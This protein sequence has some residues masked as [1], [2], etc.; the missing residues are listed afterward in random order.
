MERLLQLWRRLRGRGSASRRIEREIDEEL[1]FHLEMRTRE[2]IAAGMAPEEAEHR[3]RERLGELDRVRD[4]G[5]SIRARR[6]GAPLFLRLAG[7]VAQDVRFGLRSMLRTPGFT[8]V[9]VLTLTLGIG[10]TTVIF[11]VADGVLLQP[12]PYREP[13]RLVQFRSPS[14]S[15][16]TLATWADGLSTLDGISLFTIGS[17]EVVGPDGARSVSSLPVDG[18]FF[19]V[20][21]A[22]AAHGRTLGPEDQGADAPLAAVITD[23]LW[24][25][26][27]GAD[28]AALGNTLSFDGRS[29]TIVG[30]MPPG[31]SFLLYPRHDLF[32]PVSV[33][34]RAP[35][36]ALG[37]LADG[38]TPAQSREQA[39]ALAR[40]IDPIAGAELS[41]FS[42]LTLYERVVSADRDGILLLSGAVCFVLLIAC[43]NVANL[44]MARSLARAGEIAVRAA[45]GAGQGRLARQM[46]TESALL[47]LLGGGLG[48]LLAATS[49]PILLRM[50]PRYFARAENIHVDLR[51]ALFAAAVSVSTGLLFGMAPV[52]FAR[53]ADL[54]RTMGAD[55]LRSGSSRLRQRLLQGL[56][57]LEV[58][59]SLVLLIGTGMMLHAFF[60]LLPTDP[61]FDARGK[62]AF[63]VRLPDRR[64]PDDRAKVAFHARALRELRALPGVT[65][66]TTISSAPMVGMVWVIEAVPEGMDPASEDLPNVWL[67]RIAPDYHDVLAIPIVR[68]RP[69][70]DRPPDG[71]PEMVIS[72]EAARRMWP[73]GDALGKTLSVRAPEATFLVVGVAAD[74]RRLGLDLRARPIVWARYRDVPEDRVT[75][76]AS[77]AGPPGA[78]A[79]EVGALVR[80]LDPE[81]P[82]FDLQTMDDLLSESVSLPRLY[83][84]V[85]GA[86]GGVAILLAAFG[87]YGVMSYVVGQRARELG[88]RLALGAT[89]A[90]MLRLVMT[91][92]LVITLVG[93]ALGIAGALALTR[94]L[95]SVMFG[96]SAVDP[97]IY[98]ALAIVVIAVGLAA[99]AMPARRAMRADPLD[100]LRQS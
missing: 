58:A 26:A 90:G 72:E 96:F 10:A 61:G 13:D 35:S 93:V 39:S 45:L 92:G 38:V 64:Y 37:R 25:S 73:D 85:L 91:Q 59:M 28:P 81:L 79:N 82:I 30:I 60:E 4:Q 14:L 29:A 53:R 88:V 8:T 84:S 34:Q 7:E 5:R 97:P 86:F 48:L 65:A 20:L 78:L 3:A 62:L 57:V 47:S 71:L 24:R 31:F 99:S 67:E 11:S 87:F 27:F 80:R 70:S 16:E 12:F 40:S 42:Y 23:R 21:G 83:L 51:V 1:A 9:A 52:A 50:L 33:A 55:G 43:S 95:E 44:L 76:I 46:L 32:L 56:V 100:T 19:R 63:E 22:D 66:A 2:N 18:E 15:P 69:L 94:V 98:A 68:G 77:A 75:F 36:M 41:G 17:H 49:L 6:P 74:T 54:A 89:P